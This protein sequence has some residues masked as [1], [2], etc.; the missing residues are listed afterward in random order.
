MLKIFL[1]LFIS[2]TILIANEISKDSCYSVKILYTKSIKYDNDC[3][4]IKNLKKIKV[5]CGCFNNKKQL[6]KRYLELKKSYT[7]LSAVKTYQYNLFKKQILKEKVVQ[8]NSENNITQANV[9]QESNENNITQPNVVQESNEN[10]ITSS[11]ESKT[12]NKKQFMNYFISLSSGATILNVYTV[13]SLALDNKPTKRAMNYSIDIGYY[14]DTS[15]FISL[16]Y[17]YTSSSDI[18]FNSLFSTINYQ[19]N[20]FYMGFILG[21]NIMKWKKYPIN[22]ISTKDN[23]SSILN[24]IQVGFKYKILQNIDL[25][26]LYKYI[27][28][29]YRTLIKTD[30]LKDISIV[31]HLGEQDLNFGIKYDF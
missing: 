19:V 13:G 14:L 31:E 15:I 12:I 3:Q 1:L 17:Q 30:T 16:N 20:N 23:G 25:F 21:S 24:G 4:I 10:N 9:V 26:I 22:T 2:I 29:K 18:I 27:N 11:K 8:E 28:M 6:K 7:K 5:L